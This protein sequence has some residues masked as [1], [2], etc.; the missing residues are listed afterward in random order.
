MISGSYL[1]KRSVFSA[2]FGS[3]IVPT[4]WSPRSGSTFSVFLDL[5]RANCLEEADLSGRFFARA[6]AGRPSSDYTFCCVKT[7]LNERA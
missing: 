1:I 5:R 7:V 4:V 3:Y 2:A 6:T